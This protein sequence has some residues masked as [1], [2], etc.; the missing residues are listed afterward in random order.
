MV[1]RGAERESHKSRTLGSR[2]KLSGFLVKKEKAG[3]TL[4]HDSTRRNEKGASG[5]KASR[6]FNQW[7][8]FFWSQFN[9]FNKSNLWWSYTELLIKR[10]LWHRSGHGLGKEFLSITLFQIRS[11]LKGEPITL[12]CIIKDWKKTLKRNQTP[13][14]SDSDRATAFV[15]LWK[16]LLFLIAAPLEWTPISLKKIFFKA[17]P[18]SNIYFYAW[19]SLKAVGK[20]KHFKLHLGGRNW[21]I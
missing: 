10:F 9:F 8:V 11:W 6:Q 15:W 17:A 20:K 18:F 12:T 14:V 16:L 3:A 1:R 5:W 13:G 19:R 4:S 21:S 7:N 2:Q